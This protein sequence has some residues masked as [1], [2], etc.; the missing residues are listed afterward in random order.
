MYIY[1][2]RNAASF[3]PTSITGA[4]N[5][6]RV[7]Q[8][9]VQ[10]NLILRTQLASGTPTVGYVPTATAN[11][12]QWAAQAGGG[13]GG[14]PLTNT[15]VEDETDTS[16][17]GTI[18]PSVLAHGVDVHQAAFVRDSVTTTHTLTGPTYP[19]TILAADRPLK[20]TDGFSGSVPCAHI[21][22]V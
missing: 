8:S 22:G 16:T 1:Y 3:T 20:F 9:W 18:S 19:L 6:S 12:V 7:S 10:G 14:T 17:T 11:G 2:G 4:A 21:Y 5:F 13:G 15:Q